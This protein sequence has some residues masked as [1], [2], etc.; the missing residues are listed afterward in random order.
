MSAGEVFCP[1]CGAP[2]AMP[3]GWQ[4]AITVMGITGVLTLMR[5]TT[6]VAAGLVGLVGGVWIG[7]LLLLL[8]LNGH[9][10]EKV[11]AISE[12]EGVAVLGVMGGGA[13][14]AIGAVVAL[15]SNS[16]WLRDRR[17]EEVAGWSEA[18]SKMA[19]NW[20]GVT[21]M[22]VGGIGWLVAFVMIE[23]ISQKSNLSV[24]FGVFYAMP[25]F[26]ILASIL[27]WRPRP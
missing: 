8:H 13:V 5:F 14:A 15:V 12:I 25:V 3:S 2:V 11:E 10:K 18:I 20:I 24:D 27:S 23:T 26:I 22:L 6:A 1:E 9:T 17:S 4:A 19:L 7:G 16:S 21:L